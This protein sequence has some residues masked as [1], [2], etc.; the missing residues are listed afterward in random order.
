MRRELTTQRKA[1][2][3][4]AEMAERKRAKT[5]QQQPCGSIRASATSHYKEIDAH[6]EVQNK[7]TTCTRALHH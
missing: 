3:C 5:L 6:H 4:L 7:S 2:V 1:G